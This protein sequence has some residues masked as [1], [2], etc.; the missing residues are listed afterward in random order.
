MMV[1]IC[2]IF[3]RRAPLSNVQ[4][5]LAIWDKQ[6]KSH[7]GHNRQFH[8]A[9]PLYGPQYATSERG[10]HFLRSVP[11]FPTPGLPEARSAEEHLPVAKREVPANLSMVAVRQRPWHH[12]PPRV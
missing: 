7:R 12:V 3:S 4:L 11:T 6:A 8:T 5:A 1:A 9:S 2:T 10:M